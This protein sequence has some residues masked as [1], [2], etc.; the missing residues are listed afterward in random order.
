[1]K[2]SIL[3]LFLV[4]VAGQAMSQMKETRDLPS[5]NYLTVTQSIE[6]EL[7]KGT[8]EKAEITSDEVPLDDILTEVS[9]GRL[10]IN[11]DG[12]NRSWSGSI[13]VVLTYR[14]LEGAEVGAS[15]QI[16]GRDVIEA[17]SF[18]AEASSS[19]RMELN[20]K[21]TDLEL[22][23]SSSGR[24]TLKGQADTQD[25]EG[26]SSGYYDGFDLLSKTVKADVSSSGKVNVA[27]S[28]ELMADVSSSGRVTYKGSPAK[29]IADQNSSGKV[30]KY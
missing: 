4:A 11:L 7:I 27:V 14:E 21:C 17:N 26:S 5:F 23:V 30:V 29:L 3:L 28:E 6:V 18:Y 16:F 25:I 8:K 13:K 12:W 9:G 15:A 19:G 24:L 2:R 22:D 1:M 10:K 20:V